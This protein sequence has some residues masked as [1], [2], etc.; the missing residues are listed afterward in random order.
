[1]KMQKDFNIK[2]ELLAQ[3]QLKEIIYHS[4]DL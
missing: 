3:N 2:D 1:M 4:M